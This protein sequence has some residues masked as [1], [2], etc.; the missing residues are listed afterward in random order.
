MKRRFNYCYSMRFHLQIMPTFRPFSVL[1]IYLYLITHCF[2]IY[3]L[4]PMQPVIMN[5]LLPITLLSFPCKW[6]LSH[7][8]FRFIFVYR[9]RILSIC[10]SLL[11]DSVQYE[12]ARAPIHFKYTKLH[13]KSTPRTFGSSSSARCFGR[14]GSVCSNNALAK[15]WIIIGFMASYLEI[16]GIENVWISNELDTFVNGKSLI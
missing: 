14:L 5:A 15:W 7:Q 6:A 9:C 13:T 8:M 2:W 1:S 10:L 11:V 16:N 3:P 12:R 4:F